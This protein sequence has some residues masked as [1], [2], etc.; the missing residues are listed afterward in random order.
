MFK[1]IASKNIIIDLNKEEKLNGD[2]YDIWHHMI[3][4]FLVKLEY[5]EIP[6]QSMMKLSM[7]MPLNIGAIS[8]LTKIG[9][10][11]IVVHV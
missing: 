9:G 3:L 11:K 5:F 7:R 4:Y 10:K 8:K 2:N 1:L 6:S